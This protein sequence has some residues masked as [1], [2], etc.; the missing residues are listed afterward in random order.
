MSEFDD[1]VG[2]WPKLI[3]PV[4]SLIWRHGTYKGPWPSLKGE[5]AMLQI[6]GG[7]KT[8]LAQFDDMEA[9]W[10][11]NEEIRLGYNWH[12]FPRSEWSV[13]NDPG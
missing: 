6:V 9:H 10:P 11:G 1:H 3:V 7:S 13:D 5:T 4:R 8:V 12:V 2:P